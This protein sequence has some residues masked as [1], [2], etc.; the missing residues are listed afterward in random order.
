MKFIGIGSPVLGEA[1]SIFLGIQI[2]A[3]IK[4]LD[5]ETDCKD[6]YD[7]MTNPMGKNHPLLVLS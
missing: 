5:V 7:H 6:L 4:F 3:R 1:W 2:T